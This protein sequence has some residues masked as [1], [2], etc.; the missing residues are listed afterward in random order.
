MELPVI[1]DNSD[2]RQLYADGRRTVDVPTAAVILG[3]SQLV[4]DTSAR[5]GSLP[6]VLQVGDRY[7]VSIPALLEAIGDPLSA[8]G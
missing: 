1:L 4:A 6:G 8:G 5:D 3:L 2:L 7:Y